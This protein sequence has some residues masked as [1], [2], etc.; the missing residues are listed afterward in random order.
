MQISPA[1]I[2]DVRQLS[3]IKYQKF[4]LNKKIYLEII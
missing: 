4:Y 1:T 2:F 3:Y